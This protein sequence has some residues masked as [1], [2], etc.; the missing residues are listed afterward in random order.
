MNC[1]IVQSQAAPCFS[2][3]ISQNYFLPG[4]LKSCQKIYKHLYRRRRNLSSQSS[5][6][7]HHCSI[8]HSV[9]NTDT[10]NKYVRDKHLRYALRILQTRNEGTCLRGVDHW[11][12][13]DILYMLSCAIAWKDLSILNAQTICYCCWFFLH[14]LLSSRNRRQWPQPWKEVPLAIYSVGVGLDYVPYERD[15]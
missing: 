5:W 6:T 8:L 12:V 15:F 14:Q 11:Y 10:P 4:C 9:H 1:L 2:V 3:I 7:W 13:Y